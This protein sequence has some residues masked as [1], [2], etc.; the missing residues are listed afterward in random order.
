[1]KLLLF[2]FAMFTFVTKFEGKT[3]S[4]VLCIG[5]DP[6]LICRFLV[7][8]TMCGMQFPDYLNLEV[9]TKTP[10]SLNT[11]CILQALPSL[12]VSILKLSLMFE[13]LLTQFDSTWIWTEV[14]WTFEISAQINKDPWRN[15]IRTYQ[16]F[17]KSMAMHKNIEAPEIWR[18]TSGSIKSV[19]KLEK[20]WSA[21]WSKY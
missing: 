15:Q 9:K 7:G 2:C 12:K 20:F 1:M 5:S 10:V 11:T 6:S 4:R 17:P 13:F 19:E 8:Q 16:N 14:F 3:P 21:G 18:S